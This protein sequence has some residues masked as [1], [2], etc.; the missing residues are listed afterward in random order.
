M[1]EVQSDGKLISDNETVYARVGKN[2]DLKKNQKIG[3]FWFKSDFFD[4]N[5]IFWIILDSYKIIS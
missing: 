1:H 2:H 3:F 4:L 5:R